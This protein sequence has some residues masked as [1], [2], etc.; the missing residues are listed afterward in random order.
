MRKTGK[1]R[2]QILVTFRCSAPAEFHE[3]LSPPRIF[4]KAVTKVFT[5][6]ESMPCARIADHCIHKTIV[7]WSN[8]KTAYHFTKLCLRFLMSLGGTKSELDWAPN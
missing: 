2:P 7:N 4:E 6:W 3:V 1:R 8:P 5:Y